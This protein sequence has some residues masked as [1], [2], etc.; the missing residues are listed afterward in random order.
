MLVVETVAK[1]RRAH[2]VQGKPIEQICRELKHSRKTVR[3]V[4][5]SEETASRIGARFS[6]TPGSGPGSR[7]WMRC[8]RSTRPAAHA[9]G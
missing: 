4:L 9:I 2:F 1:G 3:K 6:R 8:S 7:R 5:R